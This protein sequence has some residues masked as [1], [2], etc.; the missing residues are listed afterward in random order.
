MLGITVKPS[1]FY[2]KN[3]PLNFHL[4]KSK[5]FKQAAL[6]TIYIKPSGVKVATVD[7]CPK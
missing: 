6:D 1:S 7:T 3:I 5:N 4:C 2:H